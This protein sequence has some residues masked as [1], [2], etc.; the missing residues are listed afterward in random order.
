MQRCWEHLP[1][2][3]P[4]FSSLVQEF[5]QQ[6]LLLTQN[7]HYK[8]SY[9]GDVEYKKDKLL[10]SVHCLFFFLFEV[11]LIFVLDWNIGMEYLLDIFIMSCYL[12]VL[13]IL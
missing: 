11:W 10:V 13:E 8:F 6:W 5:D 3:R 4:I 7:V 2:K 1:E 12:W 9:I